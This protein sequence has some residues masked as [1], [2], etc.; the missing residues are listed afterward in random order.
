MTTFD[1]DRE[2]FKNRSIYQK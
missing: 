1:F 2:Y